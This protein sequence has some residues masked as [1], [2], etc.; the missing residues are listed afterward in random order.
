M[1]NLFSYVV[2]PQN[3]MWIVPNPPGGIT[4]H[5]RMWFYMWNCMW[6]FCKGI[7]RHGEVI[8][9]I[10]LSSLATYHIALRHM[11]TSLSLTSV[12]RSIHNK[13]SGSPLYDLKWQY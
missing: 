4:T 5:N 13:I 10:A 8:A 1:W 9:S 7:D 12:V 3:H 2:L 6:D 11:L